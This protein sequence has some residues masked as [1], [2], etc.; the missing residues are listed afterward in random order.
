MCYIPEEGFTPSEMGSGLSEP[1]PYRPAEEQVSSW[2]IKKAFLEPGAGL[3]RTQPG[4]KHTP[5]PLGPLQ[6]TIFR[7]EGQVLSF[8][9]PA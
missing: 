2:S 7:Q 9:L 4:R 5:H 8:Q 1:H 6:Q 3:R